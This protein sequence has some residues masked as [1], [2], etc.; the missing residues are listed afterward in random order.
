MAGEA[1]SIP[2]L[3]MKGCGFGRDGRG[4]IGGEPKRMTIGGGAAT[5]SGVTRAPSIPV[6]A[7][8]LFALTY[9]LVGVVLGA[10]TPIEQE[11]AGVSSDI[12]R[13]DVNALREYLDEFGN[14]AAVVAVIVM[15]VQAAFLPIPGFVIVFANG[16]AFGFVGGVAVSLLGY[17][18]SASVCFGATRFL[19]RARVEW[20]VHR[21]GLDTIDRWIARYGVSAV[22]ALRLAPGFAFDGVSY[23]A[24]LTGVRFSRFVVA[25][26]LGS[27]PQTL[28]FVYLGERAT[29]HLWWIVVGGMCFAV[30][31][32]L[33][34]YLVG[35]REES[36]AP[37]PPAPLP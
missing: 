16:L 21:L 11:V 3:P 9:L 1:V 8:G 33:V 18:V 31:A 23:A 30:V 10:P 20:L 22:F 15:V 25:S 26:V 32:L 2:T 34:G 13:G 12:V 4:R 6:M 29:E 14:G 5:V 36:R 37:S 28:L 17:A 19:G 24:G 35:R 7:F 27:M